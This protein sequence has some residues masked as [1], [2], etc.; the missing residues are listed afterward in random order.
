MSALATQAQ[1]SRLERPFILMEPPQLGITDIPSP[2]PDDPPVQPIIGAR[3]VIRNAGR[4]PAFIT[5]H[6]AGWKRYTILPAAPEYH[7]IQQ[8][9]RPVTVPDKSTT[10][11]AG[12]GRVRGYTDEE[13]QDTGP[14]L[15]LFLFGYI[16][17]TDFLQTPHRTG[18]CWR[19]T[20]D[21]SM[22]IDLANDEEGR[23][24]NY[25]T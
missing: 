24:Y 10:T 8:F 18:F 1:F 16:D 22:A 20:P 19:I 25:Y 4:T 5:G 7:L 15:Y 17:Y 9:N 12:G 6:K 21:G 13:S 3:L 23:A 2:F 14:F 11:L